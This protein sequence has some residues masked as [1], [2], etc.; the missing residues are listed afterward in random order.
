MIKTF[1]KS[2]ASKLKFAIG[3]SPV[4]EF[5][6]DY[7]KFIPPPY[8]AVV[9]I[10]ADFELAWAWQW[11]KVKDPLRLA[12]EKAMLSRE[13]IPKI[14]NLCEEFQI[15]I[16]WLTVGHL[17]LEHCSNHDDLNTLNH[18]E[19]DFWKFEKSDWFANDPFSDY[20]TAPFWYAPDLI[21]KIISTSVKHEIGCHTFSHIDCRDNVCPSEVFNSE[22]SACLKEAEKYDIPLKS[23]V[24]P[25]HTIGNLNNLAKFGFT[26]FR[27][28]YN[29]VLGYPVKHPNGLWEFKQTVELLFRKEW[30][31]RYHVKRYIEILKRAINSNTVAVL[32]FH[33]SF[34]TVVA[35]KILPE[36]FTFLNK[37]KDVIWVTTH[38]EYINWLNSK[39]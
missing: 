38:S 10:S 27:T 8:K 28:N 12:N 13:N 17:F 6:P 39:Q 14:L 23:F 25:A 3:K 30:S 29:N 19:N 24:H 2:K 37:N 9:V 7:T 20:K 21:K 22:I 1:L 34:Q 11:A 4:V 31:I 18:F 16:T 35:D 5:S 32:W 15:P 33:P 26:N 36:L